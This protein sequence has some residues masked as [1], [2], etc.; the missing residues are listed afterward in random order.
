MKINDFRRLM[1]KPKYRY[2]HKTNKW[3][4][5][6]LVT[7]PPPIILLAENPKYLSLSYCNVCGNFSNIDCEL[8]EFDEDNH[9]CGG[10]PTCCP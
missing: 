4:R 1:D 9:Y 2:N 7:N 6:Y 3:D 10:S 8:D 5:V